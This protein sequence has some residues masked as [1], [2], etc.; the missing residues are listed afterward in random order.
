[1]KKAGVL[2]GLLVFG[3]V[4]VFAGGRLVVGVVESCP[5]GGVVQVS[6]SYVQAVEAAGFV[7]M[8]L[9]M[10][11]SEATLREFVGKIDI[12]LLTGG[13]DVEPRRYGEPNSPRLG[14][15]NFSRDDF[16]WKLLAAARAVRLPVFGIC[17]GEQ[18]L[19]VFFGG[20]LYQDIPSEFPRAQ[21]APEVVHRTKDAKPVHAVAV[22]PGTRLGAVAGAGELL[23]NTYHHQSVKDL[24]PGFVASAVSPDGVV[25]AI[26]SSDYPAAGV[27]FHPEKILSRNDPVFDRSRMAAIFSRLP[28][29]VGKVPLRQN[30][31]GCRRDVK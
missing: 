23:V 6:R 15:V 24:A 9:P 19:N 29:L 12:L 26:E 22:K 3:F 1:M 28:E 17:R 20:T 13:E 11:E 7:P 10:A 30:A 18:M 4:S 8:V 2:L 16:E 5:T 27:Q 14:K 25:E 31:C 21:N